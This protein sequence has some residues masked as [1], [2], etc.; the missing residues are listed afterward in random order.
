MQRLREG[1]RTDRDHEKGPLGR[2]PQHSEEGL[3][4]SL[5][6]ARPGPPVR[7]QLRRVLSALLV[8]LA[9]WRPRH[10]RREGQVHLEVLCVSPA[11]HS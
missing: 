6:V 10:S 4:P 5:H 9:L 3:L 1:R 8:G 7:D 11:G 2:L